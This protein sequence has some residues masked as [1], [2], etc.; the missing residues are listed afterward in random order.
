LKEDSL[1]ARSVDTRFAVGAGNTAAAAVLRIALDVGACA[2]TRSLASATTLACRANLAT[3]TC[4]P[5]GP[6]VG[7]VRSKVLAVCSARGA[8]FGADHATLTV[9]AIARAAVFACAG[10]VRGAA[11]L[12][13]ATEPRIAARIFAVTRAEHLARWT[14]HAADA[15][16]TL[17]DSRAWRTARAAVFMVGL[18]AYASLATNGVWRIASGLT[19]LALHAYLTEHTTLAAGAAIFGI[20]LKSRAQTGALGLRRCTDHVT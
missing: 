19:T 8:I 12:G 14:G 17:L 11:T 13:C 9:N 15:I 5:T 16:V 2:K 3:G 20:F 7:V 6:A 4:T 18:Q 1:F 10:W